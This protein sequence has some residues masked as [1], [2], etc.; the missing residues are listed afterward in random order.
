MARPDV[1]RLLVT[2]I[3]DLISVLRELFYF[4][5]KPDKAL[6]TTWEEL[7]YAFEAYGKSPSR[8]R[9]HNSIRSKPMQGKQ[10][11]TAD[12]ITEKVRDWVREGL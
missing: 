1:Q 5:L 12:N 2:Y 10:I 11:V 8:Q 7:Q 4:T 6:A 9:I 3:V